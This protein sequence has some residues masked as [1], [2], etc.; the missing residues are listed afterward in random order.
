M[1][2]NRKH[3]KPI[4][5]KSVKTCRSTTRRE[6]L[7]LELRSWQLLRQP[8]RKLRRLSNKRKLPISARLSK[9]SKRSRLRLSKQKRL[10]F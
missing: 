3:S 9:R 5:S 7:K 4:T 1:K 6:V 2:L 10:L 8:S